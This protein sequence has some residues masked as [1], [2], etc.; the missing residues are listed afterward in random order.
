MKL[1]TTLTWMLISWMGIGA[2]MFLVT[3]RTLAQTV[4]SS[5]LE[6]FQQNNPNDLS[7]VLNNNSGV[8]GASLM[9]LINRIQLQ[10]G[11]SSGEFAAE[12]QE[13]LNSAAA[14]FRDKQRQQI[15]PQV[16]PIVPPAT[17]AQPAAQ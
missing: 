17:E 15:Q 8:G 14:E 16:Q 10:G 7:S 1:R 13:N 9:N 6:D 4:T 5:P 2:T 12:Q 3:Q 11:R